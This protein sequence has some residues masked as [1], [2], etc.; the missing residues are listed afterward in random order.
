M[1]R[2]I[3]LL[4]TC[5]AL[6]AASCQPPQQHPVPQAQP[7]GAAAL[8]GAQPEGA[9]QAEPPARKGVGEDY[10]AESYRLVSEKDEIVSVLNNGL[11]VITKRVSSPAVAVRGY[12]LTGGIYEGQWLGGGLSH[13]LEH[14]VAGGSNGRRSEEQNKELLQRIGNNSNAYTSEDQT[15]F[16]VNTTPGH[17]EEAVDLVTGW[18]FTAKITPDEYAREYQVVQREL[19][20][21]KGEPD[22]QFAYLTAMNRYRQSPARVPVIGYQAVI[23]GLSRDDVYRYYRQ[24]Y[25]PNNMLFVVAGDDDPEKMLRAVRKYSA[26]VP[27]GRVFSHDIAE[28]P[29]VDSRRTLAAT[30]PKLGQARLSLGFASV[31]QHNPDMYALDLLAAVLGQG[32]S[33]LLVQE[34]R[35]KRQLV[36]AIGASD[37]TPAYVAGTFEVT[38]ELDPEKV[39]DATAAVLDVLDSVKK[40]GVDE[41]RLRRAKTLLRAARVQRLQTV[42]EIA[43]SLGDDF[44]STGDPHFS[45]LYLKRI[46]EVTV[47]DLKT[48]AARYFDRGRLLTTTLFPAEYA[49]AA[50]LAK[51]EDV[52]RPTATTREVAKADKGASEIRR[53]VLDDGTVLLT[54]R[55]TSSPVVA[56]QMYSLGGVTA[57]DA[58]TNGLGN[59]TMSTLTRGTKSRTAAQIAEFFDSIGGAMDASCGKNTWSWDATCLA[60][61]FDKAFEAYA[62]V[63]N[64]PTFPQDETAAQ[65]KRILAAIGEQD[66]DWFA[67]AQRYFKKQFF[68]PMNS[69]YQFAPI[70]TQKNVESFTTGQM[71]DWYWQKVQSA[72]RVLAVFG[73]VDPDH[74][75]QLAADLLGKGQKHPAPRPPEEP[76]LPPA[77][78]SGGPPSVNVT[79]VDVQKT[80]QALAGVVIGFDSKSVVGDPATYPLT[81]I[82]TLTSGYTYPT[83]YIFE[84]L[85]GLGLVYMA[86]AQ[87]VPGRDARLPG[88]FEAYAGCDP[89]N[90]NKVVELALLN[91]ARVEGSMKDVQEDW[92]KRAGELI[93]VA[94]A[95]QWE[96]PAAQAQLAAV[97]EVLGLGYA[98]HD[99]FADQ[100]RKVT[101]GQVQR[102][103]RS[104]LKDCIVTISTPNP[105]LVNIKPGVRTYTSFPPV[106]LAP[107]GVQHD[108]AATGK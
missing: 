34:I 107:K 83:G 20:M 11:V 49:G 103:A 27:P 75:R 73:D 6:T 89:K 76:N 85:R 30:F 79:R 56:I 43:G 96:T 41:A 46:D 95:M 33:S 94:D 47:N 7:A 60:R 4:M 71:K 81:M 21:G 80:E 37:D 108:V 66:A 48:A 17:M 51:V 1:T 26:D 36:S 77:S 106:D 93:V 61:D 31:D 63:V 5:A 54:R 18:M 29:P 69:P 101:L 90:V 55:I 45:D 98:Y 62:D 16:F 91:I 92:F 64:N 65:K 9:P 42:E 50:G 44:I 100:I 86:D 22:R 58:D 10:G 99:Q 57:E 28:E 88:T 3:R 40:D 8:L 84:T 25:V 23:Q 68:G 74:A 105:E 72:P 13:L 82:D 97:D 78:E 2:V 39:T 24:A 52:L 87:D 59:L 14:L 67:Q 104:R 35:D 12:A 19:E 15:A 102:T 53:S 38:M 32:E 70:G